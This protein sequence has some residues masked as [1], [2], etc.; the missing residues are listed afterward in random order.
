MA[1][2]GSVFS[3]SK[4][5]IV[6]RYINEWVMQAYATLRSVSGARPTHSS[7]KV[8]NKR[9]RHQLL[10]STTTRS[11]LRNHGWHI[12]SIL[13]TYYSLSLFPLHYCRACVVS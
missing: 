10:S 11:S 8:A 5:G 13:F 3:V 9:Q 4:Q 1:D 12:Q 6:A 2:T 7:Q